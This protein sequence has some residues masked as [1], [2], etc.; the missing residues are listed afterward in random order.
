MV[1]SEEGTIKEHEEI[2]QEEHGNEEDPIEAHEEM[3]RE[4]HQNEEES[5]KF[6]SLKEPQVDMSKK[7][8]PTTKFDSYH[9]PHLLERQQS[10]RKGWEHPRAYYGS[11]WNHKG[12]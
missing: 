8:E 12:K 3:P 4:E 9:H 11:R 7:E 6:P 2:P 10:S 5:I 1:E